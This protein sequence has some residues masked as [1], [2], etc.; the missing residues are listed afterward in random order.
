MK[1][2][3]DLETAE[4]EH[5]LEER[6]TPND[7]REIANQRHRESVTI[8]DGN[9]KRW[10]KIEGSK[11]DYWEKNQHSLELTCDELS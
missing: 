11:R 10:G 2:A 3:I 6:E 5:N 4:E 1:T 7:T 9:I 8:C